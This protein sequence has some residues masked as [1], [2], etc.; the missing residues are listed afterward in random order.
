MSYERMEKR[1]A[2]LEA[3]VAKWLSTAEAADAEEDNCGLSIED[4]TPVNAA[5][6]C[7]EGRYEACSPASTILPLIWHRSL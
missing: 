1:A 6:S 4:A 3:E 2:E 7:Q 5:P